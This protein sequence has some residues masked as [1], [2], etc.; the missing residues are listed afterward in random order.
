MKIPLQR[1]AILSGVT[2]VSVATVLVAGGSAALDQTNSAVQVP[3][4]VVA[5]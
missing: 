4:A 5:K 3:L 2:V 1:T